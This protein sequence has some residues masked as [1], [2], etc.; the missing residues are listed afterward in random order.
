MTKVRVIGLMAIMLVVA[1]LVWAAGSQDGGE[2]E[3]Y[4]W[5]VAGGNPP[6]ALETQATQMF[7]DLARER[8]DGRLDMTLFPSFQ[9]GDSMALMEMVSAGE[10]EVVANTASWH[11]RLMPEWEILGFPYVV[12]DPAHLQ[13]IHESDWF[14]DIEQRYYDEHQIK[15]IANN[16][17]RLPRQ[18]LHNSQAMTTPEDVEGVKLR[19]A[20]AKIFVEPWTDFG[21]DVTIVPWG[22]T[23]VALQTGLVEGMD[24]P[25][26][27]IYP[28]KFYE[29]AP[30]VTLTSH[31]MDTFDLFMSARH[32][33]MLSPELQGILTDSAEEALKWYSDQMDGVWAEH[34]RLLRAEGVQFHQPNFQAWRAIAGEVAREWEAEGE[35]E[36]GLFD[37]VQNF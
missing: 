4:E 22:E 37:R 21:A 3:T 8:S 32:W 28:Q 24:A 33:E 35:W 18:L 14:Q 12:K 30:H 31:Q 29:G 1:S 27:L 20:D 5:R 6:E 16:G 15:I 36:A 13:R 19:M 9:L 34:Q 10:V 25:A 2:M 17:F 26:N 11:T 7:I 23:A